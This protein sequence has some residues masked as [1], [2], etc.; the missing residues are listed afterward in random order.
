MDVKKEEVVIVI[1]VLS[2]Y[3]VTAITQITI[4]AKRLH[5]IT[6]LSMDID[7]RLKYLKLFAILNLT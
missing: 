3:I 4:H 7:M 5:I 1:I 2:I 6:F